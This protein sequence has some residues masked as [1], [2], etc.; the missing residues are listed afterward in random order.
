MEIYKKIPLTTLPNV[1]YASNSGKIYRKLKNKP[2][3]DR[4]HG[5]E[6]LF[7]YGEHYLRELKPSINL[8]GYAV[9]EVNGFSRAI[10]RLVA[11]AF[12]PNPENKPQINHK[13]GLK[14]NNRPENLEWCTNKE[15]AIHAIKVLGRKPT[16]GGVYKKGVENKKTKIIYDKIQ[17]LLQT[18]NLQKNEIAII[19]NVT[20]GIVKRCHFQRKCKR[21]DTYNFRT[22]RFLK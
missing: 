17:E 10:H 1:Y 4:T 12:I 18:T 21:P 16:Y 2:R 15:N 19:L 22:Q 20:Y 3:T 8:K 7:V 5:K 14:L 13:D 9:V 6:I 11:F